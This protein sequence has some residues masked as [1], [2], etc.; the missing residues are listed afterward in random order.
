MSDQGLFIPKNFKENPMFNE[1][2][3]CFIHSTY[4]WHDQ[5]CV[6]GRET[7]QSEDNEETLE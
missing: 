3:L 6:L 2:Q 5:S 1:H 7:G 4:V